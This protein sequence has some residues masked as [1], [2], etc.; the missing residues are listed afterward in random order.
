MI[1]PHKKHG[2]AVLFRLSS[3]VVTAVPS[4]RFKELFEKAP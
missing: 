3:T 2:N 4:L 1:T